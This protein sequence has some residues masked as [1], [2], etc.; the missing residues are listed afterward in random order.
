MEAATKAVENLAAKTTTVAAGSGQ[1]QRGPVVALAVTG[2]VEIARSPYVWT[3]QGIQ[4]Q[5]H[6]HPKYPRPQPH[7]HFEESH[8]HP[9]PK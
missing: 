4:Y 8:F 7:F 1:R 2:L 6:P 5:T 9:H 3:N